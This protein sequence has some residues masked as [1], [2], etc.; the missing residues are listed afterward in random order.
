MAFFLYVTTIVVGT[1]SALLYAPLK[2][3]ATILGFFRPLG[4]WQ[5]VHG[6]ENHAIDGTV[7]CE[8]LH[9]H[10]PSD[11]LYSA[12]G[13]DIEKAAGWFPGYVATIRDI[14]HLPCD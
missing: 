13:G 6:I 14:F 4:S 7:A 10:E 2:R 9:Y 8:D 11:M 3:E 12:C 1:L 5:N